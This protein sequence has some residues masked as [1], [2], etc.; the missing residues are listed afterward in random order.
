MV[1]ARIVDDLLEEHRDLRWVWWL[2]VSKDH[3]DDLYPNWRRLYDILHHRDLLPEKYLWFLTE[4]CDCLARY[5]ITDRPI[6]A[7]ELDHYWR[8]Y[9]GGIPTAVFRRTQPDLRRAVA[10]H[11]GELDAPIKGD[12]MGS[13]RSL[14]GV[15]P[16]RNSSGKIT[17]PANE[18]AY[19]SDVRAN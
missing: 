16:R 11:C 7:D 4:P 14:P 9:P 1:A 6:D 3:R 8:R 17:P 15:S 12:R 5:V 2:P 18:I 10:A 19:R 13:S